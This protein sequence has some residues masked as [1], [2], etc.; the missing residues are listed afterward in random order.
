MSTICKIENAWVKLQIFP[1]VSVYAEV[2]SFDTKGAII[3]TEA[4]GLWDI[5]QVYLIM[6]SH[7]RP[8][9]ENPGPGAE[10]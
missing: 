5:V 3:L 1:T 7:P 9:R 4:L 8:L 6:T 10:I 2:V